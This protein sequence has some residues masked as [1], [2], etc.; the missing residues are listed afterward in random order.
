[1]KKNRK[2]TLARHKKWKL[3]KKSCYHKKKDQIS[4]WTFIFQMD[5]K[6]SKKVMRSDAKIT[7]S[8]M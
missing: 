6:S 2:L 5:K 7:E 4:K 1:M 8:K 3:P